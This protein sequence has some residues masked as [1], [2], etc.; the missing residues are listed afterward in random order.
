MDRIGD[1]QEAEEIERL[2]DLPVMAG[3]R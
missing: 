1:L 3:S 2:P